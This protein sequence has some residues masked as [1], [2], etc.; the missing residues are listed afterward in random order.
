[1]QPSGSEIDKT[2]GVHA[3][4]NK[5]SHS[6]DE[7]YPLQASKMKD[8]RHP[9]KPLHRSEMNLDATIV[10]EEDSEEDD[11]HMVT[12]ANRQLH[13]QSSQ[14]RRHSLNNTIGSH[15]D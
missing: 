9:A 8:I 3:S 5:N 7:G 10:S 13:R 4:C 14:T 1:M 6:E 2:L 12:G 15:A 11:Y